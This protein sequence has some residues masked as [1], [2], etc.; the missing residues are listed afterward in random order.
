MRRLFTEQLCPSKTVDFEVEFGLSALEWFSESA[1]LYER[2]KQGPVISAIE[3][4]ES[5]RHSLAQMILNALSCTRDDFIRLAETHRDTRF[6]VKPYEFNPLLI[7]P[8]IKKGSEYWCCFPELVAVAATRGL[9]FELRKKAGFSERFGK[10]FEWYCEDI[11]RT[12]TSNV[13]VISEQEERAAGWQGKT[14]DLT[15]I[16]GGDAILCEFKSSLLF[17]DSKK[18]ASPNEILRD[19]RKNL[20][21]SEEKT[22]LFQIAEKI[23]AIKNSRLPPQLLAHYKGVKNYHAVVIFHDPIYMANFEAGLK[24]LVKSEL[25][26]AGVQE[27]SFQLWHADEL[28]NLIRL[29]LTGGFFEAVLKKFTD[30]AYSQWDLNTY[31]CD[32]S[33]ERTLRPSIFIPMGNGRFYE[34][35]RQ[36]EDK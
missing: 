6:L 30:P 9:Y 14:N 20:V 36:I 29:T 22:G 32:L 11:I 19:I 25:K 13:V 35:P 33:G 10:A 26:K 23:D 27:L 8:I 15:L 24:G 21:N 17:A 31:L 18:T 1:W 2:F 16:R 7:K 28:E 3:F 12:R 34:L 5:Y 4:E